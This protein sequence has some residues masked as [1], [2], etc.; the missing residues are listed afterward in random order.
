MKA[1]ADVEAASK[2]H[3]H[4]AP[5]KNFILQY[6]S[7]LQKKKQ[8]VQGLMDKEKYKEAIEVCRVRYSNNVQTL[9]LIL[10]LNPNDADCFLQRAICKRSM[11][12]YAAAIQD[13]YSVINQSG[14]SHEEAERLI[15]VTFFDIAEGYCRASQFELAIKHY[16]QAIK[17]IQLADFYVKRGDCFYTLKKHEK[18]LR[19][20]KKAIKIEDNDTG[21]LRLAMLYNEWGKLLFQQ[22][23]YE[24]AETEF[25]KSISVYKK[26]AK[27][28]LNRAK[29]R[30]QVK[31]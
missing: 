30:L 9:A 14:G 2:H 22:R 8:E 17:W 4:W 31:V 7:A 28:Y 6:H 10:Q 5:V 25:S 12:A 23:S 1:K 3:S 24:A 20:Y 13:L 26:S 15:G 11:R 19:D 27:L 18:A 16:T 29:V 21:K